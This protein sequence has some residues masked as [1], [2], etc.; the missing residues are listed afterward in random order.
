MR[1]SELI[2]GLKVVEKR[3]D[4]DFEVRGITQDSR[5]ASEGFIFFAVKGSRDDGLRYAREV[6]RK[7][8]IVITDRDV[9]D[10]IENGRYIRVVDIT[11]A[12]NYIAAEFFG[13][14]YRYMRTIGVTGTNGKS[15]TTFLIESIARAC[16]LECGVIGTINYRYKNQILPAPNTTPDPIKLFETLKR[17]KDA[18]VEVVVME[19]SSHGLALRRTEALKFD[20]VIFT[21]LSRDHLDFHGSIEEYF[22]AKRLLFTKAYSRDE[23]STALINVD[24]EYGRR[25]LKE[26]FPNIKGYSLGDRNSFVSCLRYELGASGIKA[27]LLIENKPIYIESSLVGLHN[28]YNIMASAGAMH[29]LGAGERDI[30][31][32]ISSLKCVPGRLQ[33]VENNEGVFCF[34]D[35]AHTDDA[36]RNV[37]SALKGI[38]HRKII[39]VFGA[40]GDRDRGKRPLMAK[41]VCE[42]SDL[43]IITN[44]NPRT[45]DPQRII[46]DIEKGVSSDFT[47]LSE[48]EISSDMDRVYT[49][50]PD[51]SKAIRKAISI[52]RRDDIILIAGKGHEDYMIIGTE[53]R[54]FSDIEEA[55]KGFLERGKD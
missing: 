45:E 2:K 21:N 20:V 38:R 28:L 36:L 3:L 19:V 50:I 14:P 24:D 49:V 35:Y 15:S 32:G 5:E 44:D 55:Q 8:A 46:Q 1:L 34:V 54:H 29:I 51:R 23:R 12:M 30:E 7:G 9:S 16:G 6:L 22:N 10:I 33:K 42:Y 26:D 18:G 13:H 11:G 48:E 31:Q 39:T 4:F 37:L 41:A 47:R 53:K 25:L 43:F 40:G 17:M 52:A 27:E